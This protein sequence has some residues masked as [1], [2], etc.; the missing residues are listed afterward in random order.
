MYTFPNFS[1]V[2][3]TQLLDEGDLAPGY[4]V[5]VP[6]GV[7]EGVALALPGLGLGAGLGQLAAEA[8]AVGRLVARYQILQRVERLP[9]G[10]EVP[11]GKQLNHKVTE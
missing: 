10:D 7:L 4:L 9:R 11:S 6:R 3:G 1:E 2:S 5:L 8:L